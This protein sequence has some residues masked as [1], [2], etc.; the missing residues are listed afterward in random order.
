MSVYWREPCGN[1]KDN[2]ED[3]CQEFP[4]GS[5]KLVCPDCLTAIEDK[6]DELLSLEAEDDRGNGMNKLELLSALL[7]EKSA[8][9]EENMEIDIAIALMEVSKAIT[10]VLMTEL[11]EESNK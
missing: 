5:N 7:A 9:C 3:P 4:E 10:V 8:E 1:Y 6:N 2:D 11:I